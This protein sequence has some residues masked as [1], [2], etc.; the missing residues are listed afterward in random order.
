[1]FT[2]I[3]FLIFL[4]LLW[5]IYAV[6]PVRFR[7]EILLVAGYV[8]CGL[9]SLPA[10]L[11]LM[12]VTVLVYAAGRVIEK[13]RSAFVAVVTLALFAFALIV[14]K[15]IPYLIG[16]F[17]PV[18]LKENHILTSL[19]LP[20]GFSF[21]AFGAIGYIYDV[22]KGKEK[23]EKDF[24]SF[25]LYMSFFPKLVSGPI[26]RK[27]P[28]TK[29]IENL[30]NVDVVKIERISYACLQMM[31]GY[32]L[33]LVVAD[34]LALIV[35]QVYASPTDY[36]TV[37]L[38]MG[39]VFYSFQVYTDFAGYTYIAMGCAT[40]FGID[41]TQNFKSPYNSQSISEFWR[42]WHISLSSWLR[43][44]IY[45]PL[46]GNRKG[47]LR[48]CINTMIVF[49]I[50][51]IWHGNGISFVVWGLLHGIYSLP[52]GLRKKRETKPKGIGAFVSTV[53]TFAAVTFAWIFF[54]A[55]TLS[56]A[57]I[58][59]RELFTAGVD[60]AYST[61]VFEKSG[62]VVLQVYLSL[63]LIVIVWVID[64]ICKRRSSS[65]PKMLQ[66]K[67]PVVRYAF[68]Y[69]CF[70]VIFIFG[71]YGGDFETENFIYMQF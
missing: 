37:W 65:L 36:D 42:R 33:K 67:R 6:I 58:Y 14:Y 44:Y 1:M 48:K 25:A 70:M 66:D 61:A 23:A 64:T 11:V 63:A 51:G 54:R 16:V 8:F 52:G 3:K 49:L 39:A 38:I 20:V 46:G 62:L 26:E 22:W 32:V 69:I 4:I 59:I 60:P 45:I 47:K 10:M 43:D 41:L 53:V 13:N 9:I 71:I 17:G 35:D 34:R 12:V 55:D 50:C 56:Q 31:W 7:R 5:L 15:N 28:F 21:Y 27:G 24:L 19:V 57:V 40:L 29:Q 2:S 68:L 18:A 30:P